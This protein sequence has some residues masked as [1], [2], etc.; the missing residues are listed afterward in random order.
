MEPESLYNLL[1]LPKEVGPP[2]E[3]EL[4]QGAVP[5]AGGQGEG[6]V[7]VPPSPHCTAPHLTP[8]PPA[9]FGPRPSLPFYTDT[10]FLLLEA[11]AVLP[12]PRTAAHLQGHRDVRRRTL[13]AVCV[14][15]TC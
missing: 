4:P 12:T 9:P 10:C 1:Q 13:T 5:G 3:E 2:V 6:E 8:R 7:C 11:S 15:T 14:L